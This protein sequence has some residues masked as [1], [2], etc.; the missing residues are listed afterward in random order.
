MIALTDRTVAITG[1]A[2]G[3]GAAVAAEVVRR[4]GLVL[5][6]DLDAE[7]VAAVATRL[8]PAALSGRL[9]VTDDAS[10]AQW[11]ELAQVDVL[12][13][14]AGVMWVGAYD[15]EPE[16]AGRRMMD[17][18]FWGVVRGTRLVLPA[19]L[20]R[21]SGHVVTV[22]SL[23]SYIGPRGEATYGAT[24][25]AV[26]GWTK[27]VRAELRGRGVDFTLVLPA[28]VET[29]LAAGTDSGGV[30]RL[31][32]EQVASAVVDAIE[33]PRFEV[34]VPARTSA[35]VRIFALLPQTARDRMYERLV[36][37]Q[38]RSTD[39]AARAAYEQRQVL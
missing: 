25:H 21:G 28:V 32:P 26:H 22:A 8:G 2:R 3:I 17:V 23:A 11:L 39:R 12:V 14:N 29:E 10:Y 36:P 18:N 24:K 30:P 34:F 7:A 35:L 5:L 27:A 33:R 37:D 6:G 16:V 9:D 19:M 15:E 4:G 20:H 38:V 1:A 13:S 31:T